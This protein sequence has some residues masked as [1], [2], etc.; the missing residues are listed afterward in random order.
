MLS[1]NFRNRR[2]NTYNSL[3]VRRSNTLNSYACVPKY[4]NV[5]NRFDVE[6]GKKGCM[7]PST[8][9]QV[10]SGLRTQTL[11]VESLVTYDLEP[12][13]GMQVWQYGT[14]PPAAVA[15]TAGPG[16][17]QSIV[18]NG[19][20]TY[21]WAVSLSC[22]NIP[23]FVDENS[24]ILYSHGD[25]SAPR[26]TFLAA[27]SAASDTSVHPCRMRWTCC[28][29]SHYRNPLAGYRKQLVTDCS[30]SLVDPSCVAR[31][32][33]YKDN[34]AV[35][36]ATHPEVCYNPVIRTIQ[37]RNGYINEQYN[38]SA[39]Q[40][41]N[42]RCR[43]YEQ[44]TLNYNASLVM[45]PSCCKT[46][47]ATV[48]Y[49]HPVPPPAT[50]D[51][52][53]NQMLNFS[54]GGGWGEAEMY[55]WQFSPSGPTGTIQRRIEHGGGIFSWIVSFPCNDPPFFVESSSTVVVNG[56]NEVTLVSV[57]PVI[58]CVDESDIKCRV[59]CVNC[60]TV[61]CRGYSKCAPKNANCC[62]IYK[63][64]NA[65][66]SRQGAVS[67]G[68]RINRLKYQTVLKSQSTY[69]VPNPNNPPRNNKQ[70]AYRTVNSSGNVNATN[71]MM[72][73]MLYRDT[74]PPYK[75]NL[76]DMCFQNCT[77]RAWPRQKPPK[78]EAGLRY[79]RQLCRFPAHMRG[80]PR[81]VG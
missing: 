67:G 54:G 52:S 51:T 15:P 80:K 64:S 78:S 53:A 73:V 39:K 1:F 9:S 75:S 21:V 81:C 68:S 30:C 65:P 44:Q 22:N 11:T 47:F 55:V 70:S 23:F 43:T 18:D 17:I 71:G 42:R 3:G 40:Y 36:C 41:L 2:I 5:N 19:D 66:F 69:K 76:S 24:N 12:A 10:W 27:L 26:P 6:S 59:N 28:N 72:P 60:E 29:T 50:G 31:Q 63:R 4:K 61:A 13:P 49:P 32:Y 37:N 14:T 79:H 45:D 56:T 58:P 62:S 46:K 20:G 35:K 38:Y 8:I 57:G 25:P 34:W 77:Q 33:I 48:C 7:I 16:T 74:R